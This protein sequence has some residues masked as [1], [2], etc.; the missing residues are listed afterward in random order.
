[1]DLQTLLLDFL[2]LQSMKAQY[3]EFV[4]VY[5]HEGMERVDQAMVN[6]F[7]QTQWDAHCEY[8]WQWYD[9]EYRDGR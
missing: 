7:G 2:V 6:L 9:M 4:K 8:V 3:P 1:M 5:Q